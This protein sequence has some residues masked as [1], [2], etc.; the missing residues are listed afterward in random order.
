MKTLTLLFCL[1]TVPFSAATAD[2]GDWVAVS[3]RRDNTVIAAAIID[4]LLNEQI[5]A[6]RA[7]G[8]RKDFDVSEIM[9]TLGFTRWPNDS[10]RSDYLLRLLLSSVFPPLAGGDPGAGSGGSDGDASAVMELRMRLLANKD[11]FDRLAA[12]I[13]TMEDLQLRAE[14]IRLI[15]YTGSMKQRGYLLAEA[16]AVLEMLADGKTTASQT[17]YILTYL[18]ALKQLDD[19]IFLEPC[20]RIF[21]RSAEAAISRLARSVIRSLSAS[22][23]VQAVKTGALNQ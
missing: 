9:D 13:G 1:L 10:S 23:Q 14:I 21:E 22:G 16:D 3:D 2:I 15:P 11:S 7:L 8:R 18:L 20:L 19:A 5:L 6:I 12:K 17:D 4:S